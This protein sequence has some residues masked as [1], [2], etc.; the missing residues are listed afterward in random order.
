MGRLSFTHTNMLK[1]LPVFLKDPEVYLLFCRNV[2]SKN[3][4]DSSRA[5][6]L[7]LNEKKIFERQAKRG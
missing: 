2:I 6:I 4:G 3:F 5:S 7:N 1:T